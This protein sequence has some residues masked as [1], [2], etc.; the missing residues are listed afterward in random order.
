[1]CE[2][3]GHPTSLYGSKHVYGKLTTLTALVLLKVSAEQPHDC[4]GLALRSGCGVGD[5][6]VGGHHRGAGRAHCAGHRRPSNL[7]SSS[8]RGW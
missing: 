1:M 2:S 5:G 3:S 8:D 7:T 4:G 6:H